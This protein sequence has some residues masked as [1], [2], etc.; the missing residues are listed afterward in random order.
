MLDRRYLGSGLVLV[1]CVLAAFIDLFE[2]YLALGLVG[3]SRQGL[4]ATQGVLGLVVALWILVRK[5]RSRLPLR[6]VRPWIASFLLA[7]LSPVW[8]GIVCAVIYRY[9]A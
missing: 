2:I 9:R 4:I 5:C 1:S 6:P 7:L 8:I 3:D